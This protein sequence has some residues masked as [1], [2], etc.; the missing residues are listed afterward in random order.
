MSVRPI[1]DAL[2]LIDGGVFIDLASDKLNQLVKTV[3]ETGKAGTL[4]IKLEIK[5]ARE[6]AV[7]I[8]P[9]VVAKL[10]EKKAD[11]SLLWVTVEG[12]LTQENPNQ[13]RLD[14]RPVAVTP[15][16]VREAPAAAPSD[17]RQA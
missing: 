10:P 11:P 15:T 8:T 13:Q 4:T 3:D 14:L 2:R 7:N 16:E 5:R 1:T 17:L 6:G 12:N 9:S